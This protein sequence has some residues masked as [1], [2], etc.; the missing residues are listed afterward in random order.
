MRM[1][2][3][4][5]VKLA[6]NLRSKSQSTCGQSQGQLAIS[7]VQLAVKIEVNLRLKSRST[8]GQLAVKVAVNMRSKSRSTFSKSRGQLTS[9][10]RSTCG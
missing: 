9:K 5:T 2:A 7:R 4:L 10:S 3:C 6:F 8:C 1:C